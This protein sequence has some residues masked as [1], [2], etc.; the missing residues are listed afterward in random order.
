VATGPIPPI[1][2]HFSADSPIP[3][4]GDAIDYADHLREPDDLQALLSKTSARAILLHKGRIGIGE[5][6]RPHRIHPSD[7]IGH[8]LITPG[9]IFL[10]LEGERPIFAFSVAKPEE[11]MP[12][13]NFVS[14]RGIGG[15]LRPSDLALAGRAKSLFSWHFTDKFCISCGQR[16]V[17][18]GGG[19]KQQCTGC[20]AESFP[21]VN[22][23]VIML[24][25]HGDRV[26]LGRGLGWPEGAMSA[27]AG[28]I[29]PGE[30]IEEAAQRE[31]LEESG[32]KTK[33]ARYVFSQPWPFPAQL[34]MG[35]IL[36]AV[37]TEITIDPK[38]LEDARWFTREEVLAVYEKRGEAFMRLP[39][40]T[41]AHQLLRHWLSETT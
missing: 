7:L 32:I 29:S 22:P 27:L 10:G 40:Q 30:S 36:E 33:N 1:M 39:R 14:L 24:V 15:N 41:I 37:T 6:G 4:S 20:G 25:T 26:L 31:V 18:R 12:E 38:E 21:R 9:P 28:F 23:V 17:A 2:T 11:F 35:L 8:D 3:F 5:G 34:M 16:T 19:V 13:E